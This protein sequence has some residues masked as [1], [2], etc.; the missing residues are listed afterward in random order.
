MLYSLV[1]LGY[2]LLNDIPLG[3][4]WTDLKPLLLSNVIALNYDDSFYYLRIAQQIAAGAG[5]TFDGLHPTNGYHP[6]WLLLLVPIFWLSSDTGT[7]LLV[8]MALQIAGFVIGVGLFYRTARLGSGPF[9]ASLA[10]LLWI[11][12]HCSYGMILSGM[13][14]GLQTLGLLAVAYVY[15]RC[16]ARELPDRQAPY[17]LLG[18]LLSLTFLAR[19]DTLLLA[20]IIGLILIWRMIR[21]GMDRSRTGQLIALCTPIILIAVG[22]LIANIAIFGHPLPVSGAIKQ[23]W[24]MG[25]LARDPLYLTHGWWAAKLQQLTWPLLHLRRSY[26]FPLMLGTLGIGGVFVIT[27]LGSRQAWWQTWRRTTLQPWLP[28]LLFA[29]AQM[30]SY[31]LMYH[32]GYSFQPWYYVMPFWLATLFVAVLVDLVCKQAPIGRWPKHL[33]LTAV[34]CAALVLTLQGVQQWQAKQRRFVNGEPIYFGA[35]WV[36][37]NLPANATIGSWNAGMISYL[38]QRRVINLDGLVNSWQYYQQNRYDLCRYWQDSGIEY[39]VDVFEL[40]NELDFIAKV[41]APQTDLTACADRLERIWVGPGYP[42]TSRH[43]QAFR[44]KI[45]K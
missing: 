6:L 30:L 44:I 39:L 31:A 11:A 26:A 19:I 15:L 37:Q 8:V 13:E 27:L 17:W 4:S 34:W 5:S 29:V 12:V 41:H 14:Y 18:G 24:S 42:G 20:A 1:L 36:E 40:D 38:S 32:G 16:F 22:Y 10:V 45:M 23:G 2:L 25:L 33:A 43:I 28:F 35:R 3:A 21:I 7:V 9:A